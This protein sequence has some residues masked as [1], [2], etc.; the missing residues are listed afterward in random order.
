MIP[1]THLS[2]R[3][4]ILVADDDPTIRLLVGES[5]ASAGYQIEEAEDGDQALGLLRVMKADLII[6]DVTM[7]GKTGFEICAE[8]RQT[9]GY[10]S[11]PVLMVTGHDD[12][13]SI[14]NAFEVGASDF[15]T[16]PINWELLPYR[17]NFLLRASKDE[18]ERKRAQEEV[19]RLNR[20]TQSLLNSAGEG[21]CGLDASGKVSFMNAAAAKLLQYDQGELIGD[22]IHTILCPDNEPAE[23]LDLSAFPIYLPLLDQCV[24]RSSEESFWRKDGTHFIVEYVCTPTRLGDQ[25]TGAVVVFRDISSRKAMERRERAHYT[26]TRILAESPTVEDALPRI[27]ESICLILDWDLGIIWEADQ[28][29]TALTFQSSCVPTSS[30]QFVSFIDHYKHTSIP[31]GM[32]LGGTSLDHRKTRMDRSLKFFR[33]FFRMGI[34]KPRTT[35]Q[36]LWISCHD[37]ESHRR[38]YGIF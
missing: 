23:L 17:I 10:E 15:L 13:D 12:V 24:H 4:V 33:R 2:A 1:H 16:K 37:P 11:T 31:M 26:I 25:I 35:H 34:D 32:G 38:H 21:I 3:S 9:P 7:P 36:C 20:Q 27:I 5:L 19:L 6:L 14:R 18:K 30:Q 22:P 28:D 29:S 8:L